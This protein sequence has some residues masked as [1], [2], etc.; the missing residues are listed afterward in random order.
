MRGNHEERGRAMAMLAAAGLMAVGACDG[1]PPEEAAP[2]AAPA[3]AATAMGK[4]DVTFFHQGTRHQI[5]LD[6]TTRPEDGPETRLLEQVLRSPSSGLIVDGAQPGKLWAF[7]TPED[8]ALALRSIDPSM[9]FNP[10]RAEPPKVGGAADRHDSGTYWWTLYE[11]GDRKRRWLD[12]NNLFGDWGGTPWAPGGASWVGR[13]NDL[14]SSIDVFSPFGCQGALTVYEDV[15]FGGHSVTFLT[16]PATGSTFHNLWDFCM[17][18]FLGFCT[19]NWND[20]ISSLQ[21]TSRPLN[22]GF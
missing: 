14:G 19:T 18:D 8:Q 17:K 21:W 10:D 4:R 3:P 20:Q 15:G 13:F 16:N 2:S 6:S 7:A 1:M 22:C 5:A 11:D 12:P 9:S